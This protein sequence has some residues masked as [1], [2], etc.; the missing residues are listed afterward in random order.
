MPTDDQKKQLE[1]REEDRKA[2]EAQR[3]QTEAQRAADR[4]VAR[5]ELLAEQEAEKQKK[6]E[7][8]KAAEKAAQKTKQQ[9]IYDALDYLDSAIHE[10]K[11]K[12]PMSWYQH[13][14]V[15]VALRHYGAQL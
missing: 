11:R 12:D 15:R 5:A 8:A 13:E 6:E 3:T 10:A 7:D 4:D 1:Q 9:A 2:A 14:G